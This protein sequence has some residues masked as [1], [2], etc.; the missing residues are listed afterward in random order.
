MNTNTKKKR[1]PWIRV[2]LALTFAVMLAVAG[3]ALSGALAGIA[4]GVVTIKGRA[5]YRAI[6]ASRSTQPAGVTG[7]ESG[8]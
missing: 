7:E 3:H 2:W 5:I 6:A 8:R 1:L 4:F